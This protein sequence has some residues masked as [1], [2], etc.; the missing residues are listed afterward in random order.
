MA[1]M[2]FDLMV[3]DVMMPGESGIEFAARCAARTARC[4]S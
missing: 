2:Q 4:P 1:V 3:L